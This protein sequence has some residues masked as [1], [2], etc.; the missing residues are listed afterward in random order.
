M[1]KKVAFFDMDGTLVAPV[2]G[3]DSGDIV[4]GFPEQE[5]IE[6]CNKRRET[7]YELC[8]TLGPIIDRARVFRKNGYDVKILTVALSEG[9]QI[10]KRTL[11]RKRAWDQI[12]SDI[13]FVPNVD[14]KISYIRNYISENDINPINCVLIEDSF[15]TVLKSIPLGISAYHISHIINIQ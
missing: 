14:A 12:F 7:A 3:K 4:F 9:E 8:P 15:S 6:F 2:F 11:V 10:A 1:E 13:I 5:W